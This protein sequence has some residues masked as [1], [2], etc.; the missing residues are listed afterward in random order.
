MRRGAAQRR[1]TR[2]RRRVRQQHDRERRRADRRSTKADAI[3]SARGTP[4]AYE[5][6]VRSAAQRRPTRSRRRVS[7]LSPP[8][9]ARLARAQR[10]PTR[11]RR[12]VTRVVVGHHRRRRCRSTKAD[13]IASARG[14][15]AREGARRGSCALNEG[16]RDRVGACSMTTT[17]L[18]LAAESLNEGRR[19][20]VGAWISYRF[21]TWVP[22]RVAQRRPTRSRRRVERFLMMFD[23]RGDRSTKADAIASARGLGHWHL[24]S[25]H[26]RS[27]KADAIASAR[28]QPV[29]RVGE[30]V[31]CAQR[32]PTRSR[33]RVPRRSAPVR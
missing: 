33:R 23:H 12:R 30:Q 20:R 17:T 4:D 14:R 21:P 16:R 26:R 7:R 10:R 2:S 27:T 18:D 15:R 9:D 6:C 22:S 1:P 29:P 5:G 28:D 32:R 13:A 31:S 25:L 11:S 8:S 19:D 24:D 3:A